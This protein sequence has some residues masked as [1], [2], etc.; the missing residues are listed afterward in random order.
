MKNY[1]KRYGTPD[2]AGDLIYDF[3]YSPDQQSSSTVTWKQHIY[4]RSYRRGNTISI[5]RYGF[6]FQSALNYAPNLPNVL[7]PSSDEYSSFVIKHRERIGGK[8]ANVLDMIRTRKEAIEMVTSNVLRIVKSI[9]YLKRGK[10]KKAA[11]A[12]GVTKPGQPKAQ[13]V[14][15]RWLELQYGW[16]P[17]LSDIHSLGNEFFRTPVFQVRTTRLENL[18]GLQTFKTF[19][20]AGTYVPEYK[21]AY[22]MMR[23]MTYVTQFEIN[24]PAVTTL[25]NLGVLNPALVAWEA[26][27]FSFIV[28]WFIPIGDWLGSLTDLKGIT[29]KNSCYTLRWHTEMIGNYSCRYTYVANQTSVGNF[30]MWQTQKVRKIQTPDLVL[31]RFKNP[32]SLS[33]FANAMSLLVTVFKK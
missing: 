33:H 12:L 23:R 25:D 31:P 20:D 24:S 1:D 27:P 26:V 19:Y 14:P 6:K 8:A 9:R 5:P 16:L 29:I 30:K 21:T 3:L 22:S 28:D 15:Q 13:N 7:Y 4:N 17:L 11:N 2:V 32:L 18:K 10:W